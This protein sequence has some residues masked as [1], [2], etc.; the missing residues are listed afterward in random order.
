MPKKVDHEKQKQKIAEATWRVIRNEGL[1][2]C[3][4]RNIAKEAGLPVSSMRYYFSN[5]SQLFVF[6]TKH[7][8]DRIAQ[9][10]ETIPYTGVPFNDLKLLL[11][12][13]IPLD[14][15]RQLEVEVWHS[16]SAKAL[17]DPEL[18]PLNEEMY[19]DLHQIIRGA[20]RLLT[21]VNLL[22]PDLDLDLET[23]RL[24]ALVDGLAIHS[25]L[26]PDKFPPAKVDAILTHH[27]EPLFLHRDS[28]DN[29]VMEEISKALKAYRL[30]LLN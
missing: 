9:R 1:E 29:F 19:E 4:V 10:L 26:L 15:D 13:F 28:Q 23:E 17:H 20:L 12:Q 8:I 5:Q 16:F 7:L 24:Y 14:E 30:G 2:Q 11:E 3:T 22:K 6:A 25:I 27:L 18:Q 21:Q